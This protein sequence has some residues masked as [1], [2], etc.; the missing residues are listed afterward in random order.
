M[1]TPRPLWHDRFKPARHYPALGTDLEVDVAIVGAGITGLTLAWHLRGT[2]LRVAVLEGKTVGS[3]T[4]GSSTGNLY[5]PVGPGFSRIEQK[6]GRDALKTVV[7][8][9]AAALAFIEGLIAEKGIAC[10]FARVPFHRFSLQGSG[11]ADFILA[12]SE[13]AERAGLQLEYGVP[14]L[15]LA[16]DASLTLTDQ[17]QFDPLRYVAALASL[18]AD[19]GCRIF[20]HSP[21]LEMKDGSPCELRTAEATVRA[22]HVVK[23]THVPQGRYYLHSQLLPRR[24]YALLV[25]LNGKAP[26]AGIYWS[27][28][29]DTLYSIRPWHDEHHDYLLL[30]GQSHE[31][32]G[33]RHEHLKALEH[34]VRAHFDVI[35]IDY[36]WCAQN[37]QPADQLPYIGRTYGDHHTWIATGFAADGLIWGTVAGQMLATAI[38]GGEHPGAN[39][40]SP[41]RFTPLA[42][43]A[44]TLQ[45]SGAVGKH[46]LQDHFTPT[47]LESPDKLA[48]GEARVI[49]V[50][51]DRVAAYRHEDGRLDLVSAVCP[52]MGCLVHWN[53]LEKSWDCPC[54]GSRFATDGTL[55]EGPSPKGLAPCQVSLKPPA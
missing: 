28:G 42:S 12:E 27:Y 13:A 6:H 26:P 3:G 5:V 31:P 51:S 2:G 20:E 25:R 17:A 1:Q 7:A 8:L 48:P 41:R 11:R 36:L 38:Q 23:A 50:G 22:A 18:L 45:E 10:D 49:K 32:G 14:S 4:T 19:E 15:P 47:P 30:L 46:L 52:H 39:L 54:H 37:Y 35:G 33:E 43:L 24:E 29:A 44:V 40:F 34:F 55:I 53:Q 16:V 21:V 9:R